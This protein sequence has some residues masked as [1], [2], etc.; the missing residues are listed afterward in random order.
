M[1]YFFI[2]YVSYIANFYLA[3]EHKA[4]L[5]IIFAFIFLAV[6]VLSYF[7]SHYRL[8]HF[9]LIGFYGVSIWNLIIQNSTY[10]EYIYDYLFL[11]IQLVIMMLLSLID[12]LKETPPKS[13][14][15]SFLG[16]EIKAKVGFLILQ[17]PVPSNQQTKLLHNLLMQFLV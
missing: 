3:I 8:F 13:E 6:S 15:V 9:I 4:L 7:L 17:T 14:G 11:I 5:Y 12:A 2:A 10:G 16:G 1:K